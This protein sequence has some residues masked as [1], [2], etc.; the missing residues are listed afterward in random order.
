MNA[1][2]QAVLFSN[3]ACAMGDCPREIKVRHARNCYKAD[4]AYGSGVAKALD[5][6][7]AEIE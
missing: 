3:T 6:P 5:L 7:I 1:A 2:Q 4:P